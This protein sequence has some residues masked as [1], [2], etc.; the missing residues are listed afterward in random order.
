MLLIAVQT[1]HDAREDVLRAVGDRFECDDARGSELI[2]HGLATAAAEQ[3]K[4]KRAPRGKAAKKE[5]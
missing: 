1:F 3:P 2:G 4:P 5:A